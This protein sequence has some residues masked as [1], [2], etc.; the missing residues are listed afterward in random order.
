MHTLTWIV[1]SQII[2]QFKANG[3]AI[4]PV[5]NTNYTATAT[6]EES[7]NQLSSNLSFIAHLQLDPV[8]I[9]CIDIFENSATIS[10]P[11]VGGK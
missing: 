4:V 6:V 7:T 8:T 5:T 2:A 10:Y 3:Q 9:Q 11:F 1:Q